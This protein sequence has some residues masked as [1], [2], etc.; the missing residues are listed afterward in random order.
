MA[1]P[2]VQPTN[3]S[4]NTHVKLGIRTSQDKMPNPNQVQNPNM[5]P[6]TNINNNHVHT[7][8]CQHN[9]PH[10]HT[11]I[12]MHRPLT[13]TW[14]NPSFVLCNVMLLAYGFTFIYEFIAVSKPSY[15]IVALVLYLILYFIVLW[16]YYKTVCS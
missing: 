14:L 4:T 6:N 15:W 8:Q 10:N 13:Q 16:C 9:H 7:K 11:Q 2:I 5:N 3:K 1:P 12:N